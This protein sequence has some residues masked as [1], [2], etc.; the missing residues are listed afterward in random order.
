MKIPILLYHGVSENR[1][2]AIADPLYALPLESIRRH[3]SSLRESGAPSLALADLLLAAPPPGGAFVITVDDCLESAF[4]RLFPLLLDAGLRAAFFAVAGAV[5]RPGWVTWGQLDE[6]RRAGMEIG[7][8]TMSHA[9][10][11]RT[12]EPEAVEELAGSRRRIEDRLG[13]SVR[14]LSLPGGYRPAGIAR[15]AAAAGYEAVCTSAIGY[16]PVPVERYA[17]RR[18]CLKAGDGPAAVARIVGRRTAALAPRYLEERGRDAFRRLFG[19]RIYAAL[20]GRIVPAGAHRT[21]PRFPAE[22]P[23]DRREGPP[24]I[25]PPSR[26]A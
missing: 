24:P 20:R 19:E 12:P 18:F 4:T 3:F 17:L 9:D 13:A 7:S 1:G 5:G 15:L 14:F 22:T 16:N 6:M 10:L 25:R 23:P 8:H 2:D 21:L 11:S 26:S